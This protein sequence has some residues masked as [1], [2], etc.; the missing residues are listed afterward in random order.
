MER[1]LPTLIGCT[2]SDGVELVVADNA[3]TDGSM[4]MLSAKFPSV[5]QI[6]LD[7]NYGFAEGY[8]R[9]LR[10]IEAEYY[11]L[12]NSDVEVTDGWLRE[13]VAYMDAHP[14]VAACQPKLL[15]YK[16]KAKFEYAGASGGYM[17]KWG[18]MFCRGRVMECVEEDHGQYDDVASVFWA[19]GA[20]LMIRSKDYFAAGG[21]DGDFFAHQEEIDLCWRL[22]SRGRGI[23]VV[24][25]S[26]VYHVGGAT[27]SKENPYK[28]FLNFRNNL[29]M[30]Y[31]NLPEERLCKVMLI[32]TLLD[33]V[34]A[35][36]FLLKL[37]LGDARAV[38]RARRE[39]RKLKSQFKS[40]REE[41]MRLAVVRE[42]PEQYG[43]SLLWRYYA[44]RC[45]TF[46]KLMER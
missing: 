24:P 28:T 13:L 33:W 7:K 15:D 27:L 42:I 31:K 38:F 22:R 32:R 12:L 39:F 3:S 34:A 45:K 5:R 44:L 6:Q 37:H 16:D 14:E 20:A 4:E 46:T 26:R 19:T 29:L 11:V 2:A 10:Q 25:S 40:R 41:N 30:L 43:F 36:M 1:F 23:V 9:A 21:L 35:A 8:N 17:D 18:Y